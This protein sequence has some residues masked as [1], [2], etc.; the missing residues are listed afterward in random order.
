MQPDLIPHVLRCG[1][2]RQQTVVDG[3]AWR[4]VAHVEGIIAVLFLFIFIEPGPCRSI[5]EQS[6]FHLHC[7]V[8][9]Q[10][11]SL[12]TNK[13]FRTSVSLTIPLHETTPTPNQTQAQA[14]PAD[15]LHNNTI[16]YVR[17]F[18]SPIPIQLPSQGP[19]HNNPIQFNPIDPADPNHPPSL[20]RK[21]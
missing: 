6:R 8:Q 10:Q 12:A 13:F 5:R 14:Q 1:K 15:R 17:T 21:Q 3:T 19:L 9:I 4:P 20:K 18:S 7:V 2:A 16:Q 11:N